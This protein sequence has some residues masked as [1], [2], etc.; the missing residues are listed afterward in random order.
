MKVKKLLAL[1]AAASLVAASFAG[2]TKQET[3]KTESGSDTLTLWATMDGNTT[4]SYKNYNEMLLFQELEKRTGVKIEFIHPIAGSTG[5][6][7]FLTMITSK[8]LPDIME[9][10]WP[11]YNGGAGQAIDDGII[12]ALNDYLKEYAPNYYD[13]MEG[14]KGKSNN[15]LY[16]LQASTDDG[17]YYGFNNLAIG[18]SRA[19]AGL[20]VRGD[21]LKEWGMDVPET[22]DEW[23]AV[24]AKAKEDGFKYPF[25]CT[26]GVISFTAG[27]DGFTSAYNVGTGLYGYYLE[28]GKV[29]FAPFA[30]GYKDYVAQLADWMKLGYIDPSYVTNDSAKI[31]GNL[32]K[33]ISVAAYSYVSDLGNITTAA[34]NENPEFTLVACPR[35]VMKKGDLHSYQQIAEE[36]YGTAYGISA[37]S[38]NI[39]KAIEWCDY[40]YSEEGNILHAFGVEGDTFEIVEKDGEKH[41]AYTEKITTPEKSGVTSIAQA[42]YK[43]CLPANHPGLSQHPDYLDS[44]YPLDIQKDAL[45]L[46]NEG[47][48]RAREH[49]LTEQLAF[50]EEESREKTDIKE[51]AEQKLE[52]AITDIILGKA[53]I[54][55]YDAAIEEARKDGYERLIEIYQAAYDRYIGKFDELNK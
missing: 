6:E 55:T 3:A 44:Y 51:I 2:C 49:L 22:I 26:N 25:T 18:N 41:Y 47:V 10:N 40:I 50:T 37:K 7:A 16:K 20:F 31:D 32:A 5:S 54:D 28:D 35:P 34:R 48:S 19:F 21:K 17:R 52:V 38:E 42:I 36:A 33:S 24:F 11:G 15:Y 39:T 53:S 4:V 23:T 8:D 12:V 30:D 43:Y 9:Y 46:W 13:Y 1:L 45:K 14:E 27:S 29:A